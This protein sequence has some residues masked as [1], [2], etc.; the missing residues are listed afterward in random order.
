MTNKFTFREEDAIE[1]K[2]ITFAINY[3][4]GTSWPN[5]LQDFLFFLEAT[6]YVGVRDKVRI[7]HSP[8]MESGWFGGYYD[9]DEE[10]EDL[11]AWERNDEDS[12][13]S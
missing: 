2:D 8:F 6:G 12:S 5:I 11:F 13:N 10:K 1:N 9:S 3:D 7:E 4:D